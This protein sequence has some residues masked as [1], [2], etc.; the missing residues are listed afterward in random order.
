MILHT[1]PELKYEPK[2][3]VTYHYPYQIIR[4][5]MPVKKIHSNKYL[6]KWNNFFTVNYIFTNFSYLLIIY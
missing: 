5:A 4:I 1:S 2:Y 3:I 6:E